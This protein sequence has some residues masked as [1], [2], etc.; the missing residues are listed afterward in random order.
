MLLPHLC[1]SRDVLSQL[2]VTWLS[3][4][5]VTVHRQL[6]G[7]ALDTEGPGALRES[8]LERPQPHRGRIPLEEEGWGEIPGPQE[9]LPRVPKEEPLPH[10]EQG[11]VAGGW[12]EVLRDP[13]AWLFSPQS[14]GL[15]SLALSRRVSLHYRTISASE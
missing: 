4:T 7:V 3:C 15:G 14:E 2:P 5:Q 13:D 8:W 6:E 9:E 1:V 10:Q 11:N 12:G